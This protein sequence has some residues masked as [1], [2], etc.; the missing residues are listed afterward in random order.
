[1]PGISPVLPQRGGQH[2]RQHGRQHASMQTT[3]T[4]GP[5]EPVGSDGGHGLTRGGLPA[6]ASTKLTDDPSA[7]AVFCMVFAGGLGNLGQAHTA[8]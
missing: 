6:D 5:G 4:P 1:M 7:S 2:G 8:H 3:G